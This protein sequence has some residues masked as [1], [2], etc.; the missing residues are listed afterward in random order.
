ML[1]TSTI[2]KKSRLKWYHPTLLLM[3]L[4]FAILLP[5]AFGIIVSLPIMAV[6]AIR[7]FGNY[8]PHALSVGFI[9]GLVFLFI[10]CWGGGKGKN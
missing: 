3:Y 1:T 8:F 2:A 5:I 4:A 10:Y 9:G 7:I 6:A